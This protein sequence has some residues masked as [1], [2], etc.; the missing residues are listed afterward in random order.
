[1]LEAAVQ[2]GGT[3]PRARLV[4]WRVAGKTGTA[5]KLEG[6]VYVDKYVSSFVGFAPASNPRLVIAIMID[7]PAGGQY[8]GGTVAAPVFSSIMGAALRLLSVPADA[9]IDNIVLPAE[10]ADVREE[11]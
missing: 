7:E 9:P 2:A 8:Y 4:G 6:R 5:H 3:G 1:M 10:G 11:T